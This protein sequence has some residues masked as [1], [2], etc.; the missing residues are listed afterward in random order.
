MVV[1]FYKGLYASTMPVDSSFPCRVSFPVLSDDDI[2]LLARPISMDETKSALFSMGNLKAPGPDGFHLMFFK[3][4]WDI[5]GPFIFNFV[6]E[7][8]SRPSSI[9]EVNQTSISLIPKKEDPSK[10]TV[11]AYSSLQCCLQ[12]RQ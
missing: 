1:D 8:F 12:D 11:S 5:L 7:V 4:Q 9:R 3:S 2:R 6:Q 10:I